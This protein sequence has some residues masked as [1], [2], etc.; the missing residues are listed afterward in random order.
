VTA[1]KTHRLFAHLPR[2][3]RMR[4]GENYGVVTTRR[5][6]NKTCSQESSILRAR[7]VSNTIV[8]SQSGKNVPAI[9][10]T[11]HASTIAD[12]RIG[13]SRSFCF[14]TNRNVKKGEPRPKLL[15]FLTG[16]PANH[17]PKLT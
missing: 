9:A 15:K 16:L 4:R 1:D 12:A 6:G 10:T 13:W 11:T 3:L 14:E 17:Q 8:G 2:L 7:G 5:L